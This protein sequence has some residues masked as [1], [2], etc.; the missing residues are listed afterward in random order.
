MYV[1]RS[2]PRSLTQAGFFTGVSPRTTCSIFL[3]PSKVTRP[4]SATYSTGQILV[5]NF[6]RA[7]S[8]RG[9]Q[10]TLERSYVLKLCLCFH[11]ISRIRCI[12]KLKILGR[13]RTP[14]GVGLTIFWFESVLSL[15]K[16]QKRRSYRKSWLFLFRRRPDR[17]VS[18]RQGQVQ[19]RH[20]GG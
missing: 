1:S 10:Q 13:T 19:F 5:L 7:R 18:I 16:D 3:T 6:Q 14:F 11:S 20:W 17:L 8:N 15:L 4:T 12:P 2:H 9:Q